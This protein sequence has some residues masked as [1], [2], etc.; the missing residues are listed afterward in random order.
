MSNVKFPKL[1][2]A[3]SVVN[4]ILNVHAEIKLNAPAQPTMPDIEQPPITADPAMEGVALDASLAEPAQPAQSLTEGS[5]EPEQLT[6]G[7]MQG[8]N[9]IEGI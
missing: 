7:L 3:E 9:L 4:R 2:I 1:H 8:T 6:L 5:M